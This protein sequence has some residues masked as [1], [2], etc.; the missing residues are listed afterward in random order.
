MLTLFFCARW[1]TNNG[2]D[3]VNLYGLVR[4]WLLSSIFVAWLA[5]FS[6]CCTTVEY[7]AKLFRNHNRL[8]HA[9]YSRANDSDWRFSWRS[10][11]FSLAFD[12]RFVPTSFVTRS[13]MNHMLLKSRTTSL[14]LIIIIIDLLEKVAVNVGDCGW[15]GW[16]SNR[17]F[18]ADQILLTF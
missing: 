9:R 16:R 13:V 15:V 17:S 10:A 12:I 3:V 1:P 4:S 11:N 6:I 8:I 5:L 18:F 7:V 2:L 14:L